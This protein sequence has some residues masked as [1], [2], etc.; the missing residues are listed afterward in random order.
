MADSTI[1][2]K[3]K[4]SK[5]EYEDLKKKW[6]TEE[7]IHKDAKEIKLESDF[8]L[9]EI[10][11]VNNEIGGKPFHF[12]EH[13]QLAKYRLKFILKVASCTISTPG[14]PKSKDILIRICT[15]VEELSKHTE[16]EKPKWGVIFECPDIEDA[17][18]Y[19]YKRENM[20]IKS[21]PKNRA[22]LLGKVSYLKN[23][24]KQEWQSFEKV[25]PDFMYK[26]RKIVDIIIDSDEEQEPLAP[27]PNEQ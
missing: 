13:K 7:D 18:K 4:L 3:R 15:I 25:L 6:W 11:R 9:V 24:E 20:D 22:V 27:L 1:D 17:F 2:K 21:I 5:T 10:D 26:K 16:G 14:R 8:L 19:L 12:W 23:R